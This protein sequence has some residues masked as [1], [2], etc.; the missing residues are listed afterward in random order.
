MIEKFQQLNLKNHKY[1]K[2]G[3][4]IEILEVSEERG[5]LKVMIRAFEDGQELKLNLPFYFGNPP[6][7]V[8]DGTKKEIDLGNKKVMISNFKEDVLGALE[9]MVADAV[10]INS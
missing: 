9:E 7:K 5:L 3:F 2:D 4:D 8:P 1:Q 6:T 10:R